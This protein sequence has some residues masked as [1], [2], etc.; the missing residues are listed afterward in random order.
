ML[1]PDPGAQSEAERHF[2]ELAT[3]PL[4]DVPPV[5][6]EAR[7]E[8]MERLSRLP[9]HDREAAA[10]STLPRL[11]KTVPG[12]YRA[13][14]ATAG[15]AWLILAGL[16]IWQ[17]YS[18]YTEC[19]NAAKRWA[20]DARAAMHGGSP[21]DDSAPAS[22]S[23]YE[24]RFSGYNTRSLPADYHAVWTSIDAGNGAWAWR[25]A[26]AKAKTWRSSVPRGGGAG[27]ME[28]AW[29]LVEEA[30]RAPRFEIYSPERRIA[31]MDTLKDPETFIDLA[32]QL[33]RNFPFGLNTDDRDSTADIFNERAATLVAT[34]DEEGLRSAIRNWERLC[35]RLASEATVSRELTPAG[36]AVAA[37][38]KLRDA[39]RTLGLTA[40]LARIQAQLD[41]IEHSPYHYTFGAYQ[42]T[43][44]ASGV[45]ARSVRIEGAQPAPA[46]YEPGRMMEYALAERLMAM[47]GA[48]LVTL[49]LGVVGLESIRR[50]QRVNGLASGLSP[51][52]DGRDGLW[53]VGLG[54]IAPFAWYWMI[55]RLTPLGCRDLGILHLDYPPGIMQGIAAILLL[56][57]MI[58]QTGH[59]RIARRTAVLGLGMRHLWPGWIM[60]GF[61]ALLVLAPGFG[62][63]LDQ[64]Q[65]DDFI[66]A[67]SVS[68]GFPLL[69]LLWRGGALV[70]GP[71]SNAVSG[72]IFSRA[73]IPP[74]I[75][76]AALLTGSHYFLLGAEKNWLARDTVTGWDRTR[77]TTK[78]EARSTDVLIARFRENFGEPGEAPP[79]K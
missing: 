55:T 29:K 28:E 60:A 18:F 15:V 45:M 14:A 13:K 22:P 27:E 52:F 31:A 72:V 1:P 10:E 62:R 37:G 9:P 40:E 75:L 65:I 30:A 42:D 35:L 56:L 78:Q 2:I 71:N 36:D 49:T 7:G 38:E 3:R 44:P 11:A 8:L 17:A 58:V 43:V 21:A 61:C 69:W 67:V 47:L 5:R 79:A 51:L 4:E 19:D 34:H 77:A 39:A 64:P 76:A 50:G 70:C 12:S 32:S 6:D 48:I 73:V 41:A 53:L 20:I 24:A 63:W 57:V 59:W 23:D 66:Q 33:G 26:L 16:V 74:L 68:A 54:A 25:E 46:D